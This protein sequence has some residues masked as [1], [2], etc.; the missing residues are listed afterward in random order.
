M[1][2][3]LTGF[4]FVLTLNTSTLPQ[5]FI[6][7]GELGRFQNAT[8]FTLSS[9]GFFYVSD[10]SQNKIY[11]ID[12]LGKIINEI[13]GYGWSASAFDFPSDVFTNSLNVYVAD[14]YNRRV[15]AFDKD[16]NFL[17]EIKS[18]D[19]RNNGRSS[20]S[21]GYPA[22]CAVSN[23]GSIFILDEE[24]KHVLKFSSNGEYMLTFGGYDYGKYSLKSPSGIRVVSGDASFIIDNSRLLLFDSFGTG[25]AI[26]NF[27]DNMTGIN[28]YYDLVLINSKYKVYL[29]NMKDMTANEMQLS[30][31]DDDEKIISSLYDGSS[32]YLLYENRII[33]LKKAE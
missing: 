5:T 22:S 12:T 29:L 7:T 9:A 30:R 23:L 31:E 33:K 11:K 13:G 19:D 14:R 17:Y 6:Q 24:N 21:F 8:A 32:L 1:R 20:F 16:L 25:A 26:L 3:S 2:K 18:R 28:S 10:A 27:K 4:L 15:Q